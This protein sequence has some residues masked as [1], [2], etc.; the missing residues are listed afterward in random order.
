VVSAAAAWLRGRLYLIG[1]G[2][3]GGGFPPGNIGKNVYCWNPAAGPGVG[4]NRVADLLTE[5]GG[6]AAIALGGALYALGGFSMAD[7]DPCLASVERY[8][9]DQNVW[10]SVAPMTTARADFAVAVLGGQLIAVGGSND[11]PDGGRALSS[12]ER[13]DPGT[14]EWETLPDMTSGR[15]GLAAAVL[16]GCLWVTG[17]YFGPG[18]SVEVFDPATNEWDDEWKADMTTG[19]GGH[20]LAVLFGELHAIGG[21]D[22]YASGTTGEASARG[23]S[24]EKYDVKN[25][26]WT[27]V[28]AMVLPERR[29]D[30]AWVV[31]DC[32]WR[33][34]PK[35]AAKHKKRR[36]PLPTVAAIAAA[37]AA[38]AAA[39]AAAAAD[40]GVPAKSTSC[41]S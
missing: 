13:Y 15:R 8:D 34:R 2:E 32:P 27:P 4:W 21:I 22:S 6:H 31:L 3:Y 33:K 17:G 36:R 5:R 12:C 26:R 11:S 16:G 37:A 20:A 7:D 18:H 23:T 25:D 1:G 19:R 14:D 9:P 39:A 35:K 41:S 29:N 10:V 28:P 30:S 24:V 38:V 40:D